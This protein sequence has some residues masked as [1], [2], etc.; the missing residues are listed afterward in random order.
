MTES[1]VLR[2]RVFAGSNVSDATI[3]DCSDAIA[4][5]TG[6]RVVP[7]TLNVW[8]DRPIALDNRRAAT[9][10]QPRLALWP[11]SL[12]AQPVWI[13]RYDRT[14]LH[15][16]ELLADRHLRRALA[17][18]DGD[19]VEIALARELLVP[20]PWLGRAAWAAFWLGRGRRAFVSRRYM[21]FARGWCRRLGA[22][23]D[24]VDT[25]S[26]RLLTSLLREAAGR[27]RPRAQPDR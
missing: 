2:G 24:S 20:V 10:L 7:G 19:T 27:A 23:Q 15:V 8:L 26:T 14:V 11:A 4:A 18:R 5:A 17:L 22:T 9:I 3:A 13:Q 12:N 16:V 21:L 25:P 6:T 1:H